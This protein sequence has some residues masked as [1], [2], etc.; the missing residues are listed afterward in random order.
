MA[1]TVTLASMLA[2]ARRL[3]QMEGGSASAFVTDAE[4][5]QWLNDGLRDLYD[6]LIAA[7]GEDYYALSVLISSSVV[8]SE[9]VYQLPADFYRA[10]EV[11]LY[12]GSRYYSCPRVE[13]QGLVDTLNATVGGAGQDITAMSY[14]LLPG[15][16]MVHPW[17]TSS[18]VEVKLYYLPAMTT[19][20]TAGS[21]D[22]ING[23]EEYAVLSCAIRMLKKEGTLDIAQAL[24][25][26]R[27]R[28]EERIGRLASTRDAGRPK[29]IA[30]TR[31]DRYASL[32]RG[33]GETGY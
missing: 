23:W 22:G 30:D 26:E 25:V 13:V 32:R 7:R 6:L 19:V 10:L 33:L 31:R 11:A 8:S 12:D 5:E 4:A 3:A 17:P 29:R 18:A 1:A 28:L 20:G 2:R 14:R 27:A 16:I 24:E 15:Y 9:T 21:F